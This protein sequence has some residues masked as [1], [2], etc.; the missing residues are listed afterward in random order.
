MK[1]CVHG[2]FALLYHYIDGLLVRLLIYQKEHIGN[3]T[4]APE[5]IYMA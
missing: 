4:N 1:H 3:I 2:H 5:S